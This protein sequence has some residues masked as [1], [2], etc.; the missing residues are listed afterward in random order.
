MLGKPNVSVGSTNAGVL[1]GPSGQLVLTLLTGVL[2]LS[3]MNLLAGFQSSSLVV[4][5]GFYALATILVIWF[6]RKG[7]PHPTLGKG[8]TV[9]LGR[10]VLVSFLAANLLAGSN[11]WILVVTAITALVLDGLDG[12]LARRE[13]R[14][15]EFGARV[16]MEVDSALA[17]VLAINIWLTGITGPMILLAGAPRYL[18]IVAT[19]LFPFMR[20]QLPYSFSR[21][22]VSVIQIAS[23]I[24]LNSPIIP[25]FLAPSIAT[26]V[27]ALLIWSFGRDLIW[28]FRARKD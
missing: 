9:T 16:D 11:P 12:Y 3:A 22:V 15:S 2:L 14:V 1:R 27:C 17:L 23:L 4:G 6:F 25:T 26:A 7:F 5:F 24:G 28:L 10:L 8:N 21:R 18:F 19:W 20:K 13:D